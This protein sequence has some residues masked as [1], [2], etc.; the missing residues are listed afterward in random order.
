MG[1]YVG[2]QKPRSSIGNYRKL[3]NKHFKNPQI[4]LP[5]SKYI[6]TKL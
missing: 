6:F 1:N 5:K 2:K 4:V 3:F